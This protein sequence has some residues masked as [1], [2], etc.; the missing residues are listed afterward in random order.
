MV[1]NHDKRITLYNRKIRFLHLFYTTYRLGS[2]T[3]ICNLCISTKK[4]NL[5]TLNNYKKKKTW[6]KPKYFW[7]ICTAHPKNAN[8]RKE[9]FGYYFWSLNSYYSYIWQGT[10]LILIEAVSSYIVPVSSDGFFLGFF[11]SPVIIRTIKVQ[12]WLKKWFF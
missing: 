12:L 3:S 1:L 10:K 4:I 9:L 2:I 11:L 8:T 7:I 5:K 6:N